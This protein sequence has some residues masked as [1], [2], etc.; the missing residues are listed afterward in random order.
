RARRLRERERET[1]ERL[2]GAS[3]VEVALCTLHERMHRG[4]AREQRT[5]EIGRSTI[6]AWRRRDLSLGRR[7]RDRDLSG[8]RL[9]GRRHDDGRGRIRGRRREAR[10]QHGD[11][12]AC[13]RL[14]WLLRRALLQ[15]EIALVQS[16]G[17]L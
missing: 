10:S 2:G 16:D 11:V 5:M 8:R 4:A 17:A 9:S 13:P 12:L 15:L 3:G 6:E 1:L 7:A 14:P